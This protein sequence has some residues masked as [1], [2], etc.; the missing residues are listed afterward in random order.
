MMRATCGQ[1]CRSQRP[2]AGVV[3]A[4]DVEVNVSRF[5]DR[6]ALDI[7]PGLK[8]GDSYRAAQFLLAALISLLLK[9]QRPI[10]DEAPAAGR[11][12]EDSAPAHRSAATRSERLEAGTLSQLYFGRCQTQWW[13]WRMPQSTAG[14]GLPSTSG[15]GS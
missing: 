8:A 10:A 14:E 1:R 4:S 15:G 9:C 2:L 7:L 6:A 13:R 12:A 3:A 5:L 11:S